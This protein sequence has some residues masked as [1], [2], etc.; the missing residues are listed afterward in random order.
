M[1]YSLSN[2]FL[3]IGLLTSIVWVSVINH[4][5]VKSRDEIAR[6][7]SQLGTLHVLPSHADQVNVVNVKG[8]SELCWRVFVPADQD[9]FL[10]YSYGTEVSCKNHLAHIIGSSTGDHYIISASIVCLQGEWV[11]SSRAVLSED[12]DM[13]GAQTVQCKLDE[14]SG[15]SFDSNVYSNFVCG[16]KIL[17]NED[18]SD[19]YETSSR[20]DGD[21]VLAKWG[22]DLPSKFLSLYV[23]KDYP[24]LPSEGLKG[25]TQTSQ[26]TR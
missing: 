16:S 17:R 23:T 9:Y 4:R 5:L 20:F 22:S 15:L 21:F 11:I 14:W 24:D 10:S 6:L 1:K 26:A 7:R 3:S 18:P 19:R 8:T 13:L 12:K 25:D 2:L